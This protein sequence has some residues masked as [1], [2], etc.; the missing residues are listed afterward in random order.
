V[1][2]DPEGDAQD[3]HRFSMRQ[4]ASSKNPGDP[5]GGSFE[6]DLSVFF[7]YFLCAKESDSRTSAKRFQALPGHHHSQTVKL[8]IFN[9]L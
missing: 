2:F 9:F 4:D 3:V 5:S 1:L 6:L 8:Q 7:G